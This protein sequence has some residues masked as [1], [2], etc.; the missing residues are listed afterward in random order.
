MNRWYECQLTKSSSNCIYTE[1]CSFRQIIEILQVH[2]KTWRTI[3]GLFWSSRWWSQ[4]REH[5]SDGRCGHWDIRSRGNAGN[6]L[7]I[8]PDTPPQVFVNIPEVDGIIECY[9]QMPQMRLSQSKDFNY[10]LYLRPF[11]LLST[12]CVSTMFSIVCRSPG[13]DVQ[14]L[15]HLQVQTPQQAAAGSRS[16]VLL[17]SCKHDPLLL[18]QECGERSFR[19]L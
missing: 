3:N 14:W 8:H 16:L 17:S 1:Y 4:W 10:S 12:C 2:H 6:D 15:C 18:L 13:C 5:D 9:I 11:H 19:A 7:Y